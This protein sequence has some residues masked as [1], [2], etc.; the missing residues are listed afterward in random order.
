MIQIMNLRSEMKTNYHTHTLWCD[1]NDSSE[2]MILSAIEKGFGVI[3][4]SSHM[5]FPLA[6]DWEVAP[7]DA[8]RYVDEIRTLA[9]KYE[10]RIKVLC[11]G[12]ADYIRGMTTPEKSR[13]EALGLDYLIGSLH[14]VIAPDGGEASVDSSPEL[15]VEGINKHF[16]GDAKAFVKAYFE[17]ERE[18]LKYDFD[19]LG[20]PD[21]VRKYNVKHPYFDEKADWFFEE[22][23]KTAAAI[24]ASGKIVE[25]NTGAISRGW[26]DDA[27][28]SLEFRDRLRAHG[29]KFILNSDAHFADGL[30]CA[31]DRFADAEKYVSRLIV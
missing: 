25:V 13:Y 6:Y 7:S 24:A 23:D 18:M 29:V 20:H 28:P 12:E 30:D 8:G 22:L 1:G 16:S 4:F 9:K 14:T 10:H 17:Q 26:L 19:I 27:Y 15:L 11:G 5:A 2:D 21:L 3:G 31:F